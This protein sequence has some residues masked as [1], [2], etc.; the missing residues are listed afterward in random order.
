[1]PSTSKEIPDVVLAFESGLN[2]AI[3]DIAGWTLANGRSKTK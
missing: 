3:A 1:V 2:T